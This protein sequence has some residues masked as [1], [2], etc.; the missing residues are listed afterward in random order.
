MLYLKT[1]INDGNS[2]D[3]ETTWGFESQPPLS[4]LC[5]LY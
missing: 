3:F 2:M 4:G 5:N 1:T